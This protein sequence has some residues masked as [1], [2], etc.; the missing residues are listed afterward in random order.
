MHFFYRLSH[1]VVFFLDLDLNFEVSRIF[2]KMRPVVVVAYLD[3]VVEL[4]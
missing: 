2:K 3:P 1:F 4:C